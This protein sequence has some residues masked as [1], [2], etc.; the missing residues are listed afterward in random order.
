M[1]PDP[2]PPSNTEKEPEDSLD[3]LLTASVR[4]TQPRTPDVIVPIVKWM[5]AVGLLAKQATA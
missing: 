1:I 2:A 4:R 5:T 3:A